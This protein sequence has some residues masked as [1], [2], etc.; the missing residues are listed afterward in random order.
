MKNKMIAMILGVSMTAVSISPA[1]SQT[2]FA[3]KDKTVA[4]MEAAD[5]SS[6]EKKQE[7]KPKTEKESEETKDKEIKDKETEDKFVEG[8]AVLS[9]YGYTPGSMSETT[10]INDKMKLTYIPVEGVDMGISQNE[11][12]NEYY[13]RHGEEKQVANSE[14]VALGENGDYLQ[15]MVE[16]N[17]NKED[18]NQILENFKKNE[19]LELAG[20]TKDLEIAGKKFQTCTGIIEKEKVMLGVCTEEEGLVLAVKVKYTDSNA[21]KKLLKGFMEIKNSTEEEVEETEVSESETA[22]EETKKEAKK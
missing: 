21:R 11:E 17:P 18:A 14:F 13:T 15:L 3:A 20:K 16:V 22:E 12:L 2:V 5:D 19:K 6:S 9:D 4:T 10:W 8:S 1:F 7:S